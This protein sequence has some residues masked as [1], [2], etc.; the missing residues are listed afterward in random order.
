[1][2]NALIN[3]Q[4][5][6]NTAAGATTKLGGIEPQ[7]KWKTA[8]TIGDADVYVSTTVATNCFSQ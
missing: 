2:F 4:I 6:L 1:M 8:G 5:G 3:S 7:I